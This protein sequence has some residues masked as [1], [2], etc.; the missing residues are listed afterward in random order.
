MGCTSV[1]RFYAEI[2]ASTATL[3]GLIDGAD[4][5]QRVP[6]CPDWTLRQLATHVG[7]A[8]RWAG[9]I[10]A[11]RSPEFIPFRAV[12]DGRLPDDPARH[13]SW[14]NEGAERLIAAVREAGTDPV[15]AFAR[16]RPASFWAR[17]MAQETA[18]HRADAEIAAGRAPVIDA[19]IAVD[20]IDEW[21]TR[22]YQQSEVLLNGGQDARLDALADGE[23][24]HIHATDDGFGEAAEWLVQR[25]G[26]RITVDHGH[27]K[28]DAAI[29]GPASALLLVLVRR[30]PPGDPSV[31]IAG[32]PAV[33]TR[34][35]AA[36][37]F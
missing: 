26:D 18:M 19:S 34:W 16:L 22:E 14:L 2:S 23:L 5:T 1:E 13:V 29:R 27:R 31:Q 8:H 3:A 36:T 10:V 15:W 28:G 35:L 7:R 9:E 6:T 33:L 11:T 21:L 4:L 32:D 17:R 24:L 30:L 37:P 20:G 12:P 25:T